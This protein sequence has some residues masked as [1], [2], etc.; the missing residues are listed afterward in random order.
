MKLIFF[1]QNNIVRDQKG[2]KVSSF[3]TLE[4]SCQHSS[5]YIGMSSSPLTKEIHEEH[6]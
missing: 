5:F 1:N 6:Q 2:K 4:I 3:F